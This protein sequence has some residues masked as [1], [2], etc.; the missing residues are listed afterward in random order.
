MKQNYEIGAYYFPGFHPN[1]YNEKWHGKGWSEWEL[2]KAAGPRFEGHQQPKVPLWGYEDESDPSVMEKKIDAAGRNNIGAFIFDW[3]WYE[4]G[5]MHERCLEEGYLNAGNTDQCKF[6]IM[7]ANHGWAAMQPQGRGRPYYY[8]TDSRLSYGTFIK[9]TDYII[10]RYFKHPS[11]W[12]PD[13]RLYFSIYEMKELVEMFGSIE[14]TR[15]ALDN[16]R[17]RVRKEGLGELNI[18]IIHQDYPIL[19]GEKQFKEG[20]N[21]NRYYQQLGFDSVTSYIWI[22]HYMDEMDF[23]AAP[24][25]VLREK[26]KADYEKFSDMLEAPYYPNITMG[27]DPSPR[28]VQSDVYENVGYPFTPTISGNTPGEFKKALVQAKDF[29]DAHPECRNII[30]V[31]A[32]NEWT[33][34]SY[35]E[36]DVVNGYQYL[37]AFKEVFQTNRA[38]NNTEN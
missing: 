21:Q 8:Q 18:N 9:A 30:T 10:N 28:T 23:P 24:Y 29:V 11:Y 6:A 20:E 34:S 13:G 4:D 37:E 16:F 7:W 1:Q 19:P 33:E 12:R 2:L 17:E 14:N 36:P 32:W 35:L 5:P 22:H 38:E 15:Y 31:N 3:Y 26:M 25:P 27:W